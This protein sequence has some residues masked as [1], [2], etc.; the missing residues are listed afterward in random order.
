M[1]EAITDNDIAVGR[2]TRRSLWQKVKGN[3]EHLFSIA[4]EGG[5]KNGSF[6][7]DSDNDGIPDNW[8]RSL[9]PGGSAGFDTDNPIHGARAYRFTHPGGAG[10]GGGYLDS[11]YIEVSSLDQNSIK[12]NIRSSVTGIKN[13]VQVRYFDKD[14]VFLSSADLYNATAPDTNARSLSYNFTPPAS[15]RYIK[16]R[17]IGGYTD[18]DVAGS[19]YFDGVQLFQ[20]P[21]T[22]ITL[23]KLKMT[24]GSFS[25]A[26]GGDVYITVH[27]YAHYPDMQ[28]NGTNYNV[29]LF[30]QTNLV[31]SG[32]A[33]QVM[34][35]APSGNG[36]TFI[37]YW[38][39]HS[40]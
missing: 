32:P 36:E 7:T 39:Y 25:A 23:S 10:N 19:T 16:I 37:V 5:L 27:R 18:T 1:Y 38:D 24:Q 35:R 20:S 31:T 28:K 4:V 6:E 29:Q 12:L 21:D 34:L 40:N 13:I 2:A 30:C 8:T 9:Y 15:A 14:K 3:F 22:A 17:L 26:S 33:R 11:D